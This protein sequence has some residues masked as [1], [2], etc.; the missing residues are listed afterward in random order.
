M[1]VRRVSVAATLLGLVLLTGVIGYHFIEGWGFLD[2]LYMTV[3]TIA[4]VGYRELA[5]LTDTG[6]V[7]TIFLI[8]AGV[9]SIAYTFGAV[10]EFMVEGHLRMLLEGRRMQKRIAELQNHHIVVGIGRVGSVVARSLA[11][12]GASFVVI[13]SCDEC[14]ESAED[15][16]WLFVHGDATNEDVLKEAGVTRAKGLV[17][18]LDTDADNLFV[19]LTARSLNPDIYIV[20]RSSSVVSEAKILRSGADRVLTP[21]VIGGRRMA[22]MVLHPI[23][24]DYLDVVTRGDEIEFRLDSVKVSASSGLIGISI[25]DAQIRNRTG[26]YILAV[27]TASGELNSNPPADTVFAVGD[28]LVVLGT[29]EQHRALA[30]ML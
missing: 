21:N 25:R 10:V 24:S 13:D 11:E 20:A 30:S 8:F 29:R 12:E 6:R 23:V 15:A 28:E 27:R 22:D 2:A 16:G 18:A 14:R 19:S 1:M 9:G 7:F 26:A 4:T 17:T 5:P 3:I